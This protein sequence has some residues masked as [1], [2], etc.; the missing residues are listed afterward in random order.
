MAFRL[1][2]SIEAELWANK[3]KP[4]RAL[5]GWDA[6]RRRYGCLSDE[7]KQV[8][9]DANTSVTGMWVGPNEYWLA[10]VMSEAIEAAEALG[11]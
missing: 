1:R 2:G 6:R 9:R 4:L 5:F 7:A 3:D 11:I 8:L 10:E